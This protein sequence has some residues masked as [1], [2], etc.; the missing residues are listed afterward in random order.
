MI[1]TPYTTCYT[2]DISTGIF[3]TVFL[4]TYQEHTYKGLQT[5]TL[6]SPLYWD[7][8][9]NIL[10]EIT[11]E[12]GT[13]TGTNNAQTY[14]NT[15]SGSDVGIYTTSETDPDPLT[16]TVTNN[17]LNVKFG[18]TQAKV[19]WIPTTNLY[20]DAATTVQYTPGTDASTDYV[21]SR[22]ALNQSYNEI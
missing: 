13:A 19:T 3:V 16:G 11:Q 9:S 17:R 18:L 5:M 21:I 14:Y 20:L 10:V 1:S 2:L 8:Q 4:R 12:R 6:D 22:G 7:G 15:V